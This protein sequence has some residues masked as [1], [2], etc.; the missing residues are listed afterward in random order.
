MW[1]FFLT[2]IPLWNKV[3]TMKLNISNTAKELGISQGFLSN[4]LA[5]RRR[6]H[7]QTAKELARRS[8]TS[9]ELW[10]DGSPEDIRNA[11]ADTQAA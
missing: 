9:I 5:G 11:L 10:M 4:I 6:P 3:K 8:G 1:I 7:Y 2:L